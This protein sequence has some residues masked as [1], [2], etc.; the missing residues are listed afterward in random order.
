MG[1][2]L[3][4]FNYQVELVKRKEKYNNCNYKYGLVGEERVYY[5]LNKC[6][7]DILCLYNLILKINSEKVQF[8]FLVVSKGVIYII[9]VKNL[10]GNI[11]ID[12]HENIE[13]VIVK[14][15]FEITS[16]MANPFVQL[17]RQ[18]FLLETYL[19]EYGYD[20]RVETM[21]VMAN[22]NTLIYNKSNNKNI[23]K[24]DSLDEVITEL[25]KGTALTE[26]EREI[27]L[28]L[29]N[30]NIDYDYRIVWKV[31]KSINEQYVP[32][33]DSK[34]D[35]DLYLKLIEFRKEYCRNQNIP[36]CNIFTNKDAENLIREKP[37]TKEKFI[38]VKGFKEKKYD[39]FGAEIIKIFKK[40]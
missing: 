5:Q 21:L 28:F 27:G 20:I 34:E 30:N 13:R 22:T 19:Q 26:Q 15:G 18:K 33:F 36:A 38:M 37:L 29:V 24:Y 31:K 25:I 7:E 1:K 14:N 35:E 4:E 6:K 2:F 12:E 23:Y 9:E 11:H 8:D 17:R 3:K 39:L 40:E 16:G 10:L 32:S